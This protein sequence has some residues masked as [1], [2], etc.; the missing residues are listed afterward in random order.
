MDRGR[1]RC[2]RRTI[3]AMFGWVGIHIYITTATVG[4]WGRGVVVWAPRGPAGGLSSLSSR[5][6]ALPLQATLSLSKGPYLS[7]RG[8]LFSAGG[9]KGLLSSR[10][11]ALPRPGARPPLCEGEGSSP[12]SSGEGPPW[13]PARRRARV[14][15]LCPGRF[16]ALF[17]SISILISRSMFSRNLHYQSIHLSIYRSIDTGG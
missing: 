15:L 4:G 14:A 6:E 3:A 17:S 16:G 11:E 12:P 8:G 13:A 7:K 10:E 5:K 1:I 2:K 9:A